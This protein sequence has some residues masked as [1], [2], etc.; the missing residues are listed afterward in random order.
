MKPRV[1]V[2]MPFR[3]KQVRAPLSEQEAVFVNFDDL[4]ALL[5][6]PVLT[7]AGCEPFRADEEKVAGDIRTDMFF[8]LVTADIVLADVSI[9]NANVFYELGIRHGVAPRGVITL[10]GGWERQPF[11]VAPDR[12]IQYDGNLWNRTAIRDDAWQSKLR[13]EKIQLLKSLKVAISEDKRSEGSPVYQHLPGLKPVDWREVH[14]AK[15]KYFQG[16]LHDWRSRVR[17]AMNEA[18]PATS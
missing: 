9:L 14:T 6:K 7:E 1:F 13:S 10:H 11:D 3:E 8:E 4:Y 2:V 12:L 18:H 16:I 17:V 5:I 15:A